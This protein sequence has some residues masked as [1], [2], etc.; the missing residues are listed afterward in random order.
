MSDKSRVGGLFEAPEPPKGPSAQARELKDLLVNYTKQET[1]EP[2][3]IAGKNLGYGIGGA[4]L[5]ALGWVFALMA[6]LRGL[7]T[8]DFFNDPWE[9]NGGTWSWLPY[10][11]VGIVALV[12]MGIY[13]L[14][15]QRQMSRDK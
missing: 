5:I 10:L 14:V 13:G 11:I 2:L 8:I 3:K 6:L 1:L 15:V 12:V 4:I 9:I 7:Q